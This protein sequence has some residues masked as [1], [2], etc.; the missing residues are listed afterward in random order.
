MLQHETIDSRACMEHC[1]TNVLSSRVQQICA[2]VLHA[3]R[4]GLMPQHAEACSGLKT[5]CAY[6][7]LTQAVHV[8]S[9]ASTKICVQF[10]C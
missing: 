8:T 4:F 10:S 2:T 1:S 3:V 7:G 6:S 9:V 5:C